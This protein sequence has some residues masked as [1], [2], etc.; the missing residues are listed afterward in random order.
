M[1]KKI[2]ISTILLATALNASSFGN[3][4][5]G[6]SKG[7]NDGD[8]VT[9]FGSLKVFGGIALRLEYTKNFSEHPNFSKEDI[10]RYGLFATYNLFLLPNISV[11]PKMGVTKT[12][13]DYKL[14]D[15][16]DV[17][18]SSST[19]FTYGIEL[20]YHLND[21]FSIYA[22]YTDYGNEQD[23]KDID[24]SDLDSSNYTIGFK[25]HL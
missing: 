17:I 16:F 14:K 20:D 3:I 15:G 12:D 18:T 7:D 11:T 19:D 22:G 24:T 21:Q 23:I 13:G 2:L 4:G 1:K 5:L 25:L 9:A 8:M 10:S 6:Y